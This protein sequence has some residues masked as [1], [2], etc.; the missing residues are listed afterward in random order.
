MDWGSAGT[1]ILSI[2]NGTNKPAT[3]ALGAGTSITFGIGA[4]N[5]VTLSSS[6]VVN[7]VGQR[8]HVTATTANYTVLATDHVISVGTLTAGI[9]VTLP[10]SPTAGDT[11]IVKDAA[12]SAATYNITIDG[13]GTNIDGAG[14]Y[15]LDINY[16]S[17][18]LVAN[19]T[20]WM[21]V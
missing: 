13:D 14:T 19:A 15:V 2:G 6:K 10:A 4:T 1:D 5:Y 16:G 3:T 9:T 20:G 7:S 18:T 21:V 8:T 17:V 12:G 11:F